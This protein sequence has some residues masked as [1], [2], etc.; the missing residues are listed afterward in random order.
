MCLLLNFPLIPTVIT[1]ILSI[2]FFKT[3]DLHPESRVSRY[4]NIDFSSVRVKNSDFIYISPKLDDI[5]YRE[6]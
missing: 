4:R 6:K 5:F 3:S 1:S 2:H